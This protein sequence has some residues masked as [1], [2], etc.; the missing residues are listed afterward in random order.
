VRAEVDLAGSQNPVVA[1]GSGSA[2]WAVS[3]ALNGGIA[4]ERGLWV[5]RGMGRRSGFCPSKDIHRPVT[6]MCWRSCAS[7]RARTAGRTWTCASSGA[8]VL[9]ACGGTR[10]TGI[11]QVPD[12]R[13]PVPM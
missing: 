7:T 6:A 3:D 13:R 10:N 11:G 12:P 5:S 9:V 1:N 8:R 2:R 4:D